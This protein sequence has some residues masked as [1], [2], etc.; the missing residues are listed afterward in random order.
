M[1][2]F[3]RTEFDDTHTSHCG[4][5]LY[6][7][8]TILSIKN[9]PAKNTINTPSAQTFR[10]GKIKN[11]NQQEGC[12]TEKCGHTKTA[13]A[14]CVRSKH[15]VRLKPL[16]PQNYAVGPFTKS[17]TAIQTEPFPAFGLATVTRINFSKKNFAKL[18]YTSIVTDSP[19]S[20]NLEKRVFP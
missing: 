10:T 17:P 14:R 20:Y 2:H 5:F 16:S 8:E 3:I 18:H 12:G 7:H 4:S 9:E 13:N 15:Y 19:F 11:I 1:L 6:K